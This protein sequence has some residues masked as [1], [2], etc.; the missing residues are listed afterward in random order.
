[1]RKTTLR[2]AVILVIAVLIADSLLSPG[3]P[4]RLTHFIRE[5]VFETPIIVTIDFVSEVASF[6]SANS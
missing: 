3:H 2:L 5:D 1:M 6:I 4:P